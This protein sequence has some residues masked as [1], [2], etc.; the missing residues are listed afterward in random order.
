M[1]A[2]KLPANRGWFWLLEG[3]RIF[4]KRPVH[5]SFLV[6]SYWLLLLIVSVFPFIGQPLTTLLVPAFSVSLMNACRKI[7]AN[8]PIM[9]VLLFSGFKKNLN[10]LLIQG[11]IYLAI[12]TFILGMAAFIDGGTPFFR[13]LPDQPDTAMLV[14]INE[15]SFAEH[16]IFILMC[17]VIMAYWYSPVLTAW[18]D[19]PAVKALFFSL[20][21]CLRNW[22]AFIVYFIAMTGLITVF[23]FLLSMLASPTESIFS[24]FMMPLLL[25]IFLPTLYASFYVS[26]REVFTTNDA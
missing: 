1:Q 17:P 19:L 14:G 22:R 2:L 20:I 9:P 4:R 26:Y 12:V 15:L 23:I 11:L 10:V 21:A 8:E 16:L 6:M 7:E 25:F 18:H 5:L 3:F 13:M 24:A